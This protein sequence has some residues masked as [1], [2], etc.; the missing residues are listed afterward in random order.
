[1]QLAIITSNK[2]SI[3]DSIINKV[4][5]NNPTSDEQILNTL[6]EHNIDLVILIDYRKKLG[7]FI[8]DS[9]PTIN[10]HES[11]LPKHSGKGMYGIHVHESVINSNDTES[12]ATIHFVTEE[13]DEGKIIAQYKVPRFQDDTA[14][15]LQKRV[16][17]VIE[18]ELP[19]TLGKI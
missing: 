8:I 12:G 4:I 19:K 2:E 5:I 18:K 15:T 10:I 11:L 9:F 16:R 13:Y 17:N 3:P 6:K 7:K 1:M 14:E